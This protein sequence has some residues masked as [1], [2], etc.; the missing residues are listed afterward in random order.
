MRFLFGLAGFQYHPVPL[1]C[2]ILQCWNPV[3]HLSQALEKAAPVVPFADVILMCQ[4]HALH[5]DGH[6]TSIVVAQVVLVAGAL[7][8]VL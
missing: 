8:G 2:H 3:H 4:E 5:Q 1:Q 6:F 7:N